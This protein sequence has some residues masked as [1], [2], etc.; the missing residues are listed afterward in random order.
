M[1]P[2][3]GSVLKATCVCGFA[4]DDVFAGGGMDNFTTTCM[5]PALCRECGRLIVSSY[6]ADRPCCRVCGEP[7]TFYDDASLRSDPSGPP[8]EHV[9]TWNIIARSRTLVLPDADYLCP[10]CDEMS[11]RFECVGMWD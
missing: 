7:V 2:V 11:M 4:S 9:F 8:P 6:L 3:V 5:A 1:L 10:C